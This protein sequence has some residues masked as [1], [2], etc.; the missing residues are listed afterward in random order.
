MQTNLLVRL[1]ILAL[2]PELFRISWSAW[3]LADVSIR[4]PWIGR[5]FFFDIGA[6]SVIVVVVVDVVVVAGVVLVDAVGQVISSFLIPSISS[7][8]LP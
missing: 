3:N 2:L 7:S 5:H 6:A 4:H 8:L 1:I